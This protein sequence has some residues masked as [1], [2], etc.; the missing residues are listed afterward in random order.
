M[1]QIN[2]M[3]EEIWFTIVNHIN[4]SMHYNW[5]YGR[6]KWSVKNKLISL[7]VGIKLG[8]TNFFPTSYKRMIEFIPCKIWI[9]MAHTLHP[10]L[11]VDTFIDPTCVC[12]NFQP[13][14]AI[15]IF[16]SLVLSREV[17]YPSK[18]RIVCFALVPCKAL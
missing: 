11:E 14:M 1:P 15:S 5:R 9:A 6:Y 4:G 16:S 8:V 17:Y 12:Y 2:F 13:L 7:F 10:S 18:K 3:L